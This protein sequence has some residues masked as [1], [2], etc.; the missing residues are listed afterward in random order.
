MLSE[1]S[2]LM[3]NIL[4]IAKRDIKNISKNRAALIVIAALTFLPSLY[5]WFNIKASWDP[6]SNT[7]GV[8]VAISS[9]DE[10]ATV[11]EKYIN[12][13]DEVIIN[14]S[15]NKDL[16]WIF[17]SEDEAIEGVEHGD[18]YA[19][20]IIPKNFSEK[21]VSVTTNEIEKPELEYYIN[22]KINAISPKVTKT[23]ASA[24]VENI[25]TSFLKEAN[26][27][28]ISVFNTIGVELEHNYVDIEKA[29]DAIFRLEEDLPDIYANLQLID[30][31]LDLA[32][33]AV[34]TV[35]GSMDRVSDFQKKVLRL[36]DQLINRLNNSESLVNDTVDDLIMNFRSLQKKIDKIPGITSD[37]SQ[38]GKDLDRLVDSLKERQQKLTDVQNRLDDIHRYLREQDE[39]LKQSTK[40]QDIQNSLDESVRDLEQ[41][42][43]NLQSISND[44][45]SG[46]HPG[47]TLVEETEKLITSIETQL[48]ELINSYESVVIPQIKLSIE[49]VES[50]TNEMSGIID[51]ASSLN[52]SA[53][54]IVT[55]LIESNT[56]NLK[57]IQEKL[58]NL[59][60]VVESNLNKVEN[61]V[62]I[63]D[64]MSRFT[65]SERI[66]K[67]LEN[68]TSL[69]N[70]L[71]QALEII[72]EATNKVEA[73]EVPSVKILDRLNQA[74]QQVD[75]RIDTISKSF[76][77]KTEEIMNG[78]ID[79]LQ[80][81]DRE[82][83]Q[84]IT[85]LKETHANITESLGNIGE[86]IKNPERLINTIN[87]VISR[88]D[89]GVEHIN[90]INS[91]FQ[92]IQKIID[93]D[94][95]TKE[96]DRILAIKDELNETKKSIDRVIDRIQ[97]AKN[98]GSD[99]LAS[100]D[101]LSNRMNQSIND[102]IRFVNS[103]LLGRYNSIVNGATN[104][105]HDVSDAVK[106]VDNKLPTIKKLL[107]EADKAIGKGK[108]KVEIANEHFPEAR[109]VV[110]RI[111]DKIREIEE[112][113]DLDQLIDL[114][115]TDPIKVSEFLAEPIL[116]NEHELF[117][118]PNY[119]SAMNPFYTTLA[120]WVGGLLLIS[121]L[122]VDIND[123]REFKSYEVY[124]GRLLTFLSIGVLQSLIVTL[125]NIFLLNAYIVNKFS[126]VLFGVLISVTFMTIIYTL[127]S[128]F[129]NTGKVIAIILLVMQLGGSGGTFP[130]QMAPPFFQKIYTF[131]PFTHAISLF[132]ESIGG[133]LWDV[134]WKHI[135]FLV[136]YFFL[137]L[138][139]GIGLKKTINKSSDKFTEKA[140]ESEIVI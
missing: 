72:N 81:I 96:I 138:A 130:I 80:T 128:V 137:A 47:T 120:L 46:N 101:S 19:A 85:E 74:L 97:N 25:H 79:Q 94:I 51:D 7:E 64:L 17:V 4:S 43:Q 93:S 132:R 60:L 26:E 38:K 10:G 20:I 23:G 131:V 139:L 106:S 135:M 100:V 12:I 66:A 59:S 117:P 36:N 3:K 8:T 27:T 124:G 31:N 90:S 140:R 115:Q 45:Q 110:K 55:D 126:Y 11:K 105:L 63:L 56:S 35:E 102:T 15:K 6:Y 69:Q 62:K 95:I 112:K 78:V 77:Q 5:A 108:E 13:G 24:I 104:T 111:A 28:V 127:V 123:K 119:G 48:E 16:G 82:V 125:G 57:E 87:N 86:R 67:L 2:L 134:A 99:A 54:Q 53:Q 18:Y 83:N 76:D 50:L 107:A 65:D 114:L 33:S 34:H 14:L 40:L 118:I 129:G 39:S 89:N 91:G 88:I 75:Q 61:V 136:I 84:K 22:E 49:Y 37:I 122:K 1:W 121:S 21:L 73:G 42:R 29:R 98:I 113:G 41:L 58:D 30:K 32:N 9:L 116:L 133:I 109:D 70:S 92:S 71:G 68:F 52:N 44:L 103:D